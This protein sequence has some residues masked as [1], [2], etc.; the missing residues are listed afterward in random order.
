[1]L[2][3]ML[4][5]SDELKSMTLPQRTVIMKLASVFQSSTEYLFLDPE[6][7]RDTTLIGS[8]DDWRKLLNLQETKNYIKGQMAFLSQVAQRKTFASLVQ[9][10]LGGGQGAQQAAK[11]IQ[12]LSGIMNQQ[13]SNRVV[14][15]HQIPRPNNNLN[16]MGV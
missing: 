5:K 4:D 8:P 16:Q 12:E 6:E 15:L 7:L 10:A 3:D 1:M 13:D 11:Q 9:M 14:V 2:T